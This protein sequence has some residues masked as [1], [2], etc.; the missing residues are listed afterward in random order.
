MSKQVKRNALGKA[1]ASSSWGEIRDGSAECQKAFDFTAVNYPGK[2]IRRSESDYI[3]ACVDTFITRVNRH[4]CAP[5]M[6][7][8]Y[9]CSPWVIMNSTAFHSQMSWFGQ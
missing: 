9:N 8:G 1:R 3:I 2:L 5:G 7:P 4:P 6:V